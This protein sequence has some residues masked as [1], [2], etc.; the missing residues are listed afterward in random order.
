MFTLVDF[1]GFMPK[2]KRFDNTDDCLASMQY[3]NFYAIS[4]NALKCIKSVSN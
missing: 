3:S 1:N 2:P 4:G